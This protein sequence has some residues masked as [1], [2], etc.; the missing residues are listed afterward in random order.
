MKKEGFLVEDCS[1]FA[2]NLEAIRILRRMNMAEF[3]EELDVPKSTLQGVS[4]DGNTSLH[5]AVH[6]AEQLK[7]PL[8][9]LTDEAVSAENLSAIFP[10]L[11]CFEWFAAQP[12]ETQRVVAFHILAILEALQR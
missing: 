6:I 12:G 8:S 10:L 4:K 1:N 11:D 5:T 9:T 3:S 7:V 2:K